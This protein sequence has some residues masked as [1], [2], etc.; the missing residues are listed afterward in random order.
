MSSMHT[1]FLLSHLSIFLS[2]VVHILNMTT[3]QVHSFQL[4]PDES[5][6]SLQKRIEAET[7]IELVH[8][9]LLQE[10]G[11][12]LDPR[13]PAAQCVLDGVVR[14]L[15]L[16]LPCPVM[17]GCVPVLTVLTFTTYP[18]CNLSV[19]LLLQR[20]WDSYIVYLFDKSL[21]KYSGPFSAR[22]LPDKVNTIGAYCLE[23]RLS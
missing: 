11:V 5:L 8:Q 14:V 13:K 23:P 4:A 3:A 7:K 6:H 18:K 15:C 16:H 9:E 10:T 22:H 21:I 17:V 19:F 20:G 1:F 12:S 2:Q